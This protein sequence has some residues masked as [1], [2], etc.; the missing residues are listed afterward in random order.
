[1]KRRSWSEYPWLRS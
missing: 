1:M